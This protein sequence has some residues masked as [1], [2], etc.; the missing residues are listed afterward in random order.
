M[1]AILCSAFSELFLAHHLSQLKRCAP[2]GVKKATLAAL[3]SCE[4]NRTPGVLQCCDAGRRC[5]SA[6]ILGVL[7]TCV[8]V[9]FAC[10]FGSSGD[11][12]V[13]KVWV[14]QGGEQA[15]NRPGRRV[16]CVISMH[17]KCSNAQQ[18]DV[19]HVSESSCEASGAALHCEMTF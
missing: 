12:R 15:F 13:K 3:S 18:G 4:E 14:L 19:R 9:L 5:L 8:F 11:S 16:P 2:C 17:I 1:L 7:I 10:A 6:K